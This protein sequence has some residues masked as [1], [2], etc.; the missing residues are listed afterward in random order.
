MENN[1]DKNRVY[2]LELLNLLNDG[3][4]EFNELCE[5][6]PI[7]KS[8]IDFLKLRLNFIVDEDERS[9]YDEVDYEGY[10]DG[11]FIVTL[12]DPSFT[13][14]DDGYW[15]L[16]YK[17]RKSVYEVYEDLSKINI[18]TGHR[19]DIYEIKAKTLRK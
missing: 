9:K 15:D 18:Q 17:A 16:D 2:A 10:K 12:Y 6:N 3:T 5:V 8:D 7:F 1:K 4:K 19:L 11:K 14:C 13:Y